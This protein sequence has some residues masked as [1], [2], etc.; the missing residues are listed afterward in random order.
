MKRLFAFAMAAVAVAHVALAETW[1]WS[2]TNKNGSYY[3]WHDGNNWTNSAATR[4]RPASGDTAVIGW[5][6]AGSGPYKVCNS[7]SSIVMEEVRFEGNKPLNMNQGVLYL[8]AGGGGLKYMLNAN[9]GDNWMGTRFVGTGEVPI[10]IEHAV[11]YALQGQVCVQSGSPTLVKTGA[12]KFICFNQAGYRAYNIPLTL[13]RQG[14]IDIT[15]TY[16][17][18]GID[19]AF[20]GNDESQR[21][22]YCYRAGDALDLKLKNIGFYETNGVANT[23]HGISAQNDNQ[24]LFTGTPKQNPTVFSGQFYVK[25]GLNW[26]PDSADYVFVCSNAVSATQG[27]VIVTKGTVKLVTGAS[28]TALSTLNVAAGAVFEVE[29]GSGA[30]FH[31]DTLTLADATSHLNLGEGVSLAIG[32]GTLNG[33]ALPRGTYSQDGA[34]DTRRAVWITGAGTVSVENGPDS[35][36]TWSGSGADNLTSTDANWASEAAPDVTAGDLLATFATGGTAAELP[37][38]TEAAFEGMVLDSSGLDGSSFAFTAGDGAT[39]TLGSSGLTA[40]AADSAFSWTMGWP[41]T[42]GGAQTWTVGENN[43]VVFNA[44]ISGE[45]ELAIDGDGTIDLNATSTHSGALTINSGTVNVR[46]DNALGTGDRTVKYY[47]DAANLNFYGDVTV[48]SPINATWT[49]TDSQQNGIAIGEGANARFNGKVTLYSQ[50]SV[51][52]GAGSTATFANGL[53]VTGNG[54]LGHLVLK[55]SGTVVVTNVALAARSTT[56]APSGNSITLVLYTAG[57]AMSA[58]GRYWTEF[59]SSTVVTRVPNAFAANVCMSLGSAGT[60]D[61]DGNNQTL[62][63]IYGTAGS[64]VTSA[65]PAKLTVNCYYVSES[66]N[67]SAVYSNTNSVDN[68]E[69]AGN[70]SFEKK[71]SYPH[72]LGAASSSTGTLSVA[73]GRLILTG[74]W[75]NCTNVVVTA[76]KFTV[77]NANAFGD[78]D[79]A[80][81]EKPKVALSVASGDAELELDYS[82]RIDCS[83]IL[84]DG[85]KSFGTFGAEGSGAEREVSWISGTGFVRALPS[86]TVMIFR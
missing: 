84:V 47:M 68:I 22:F 15:T 4:G 62:N 30:S 73:A 19:I 58:S 44:P 86:G 50:A 79:R 49:T 60:L 85:V 78:E 57:N 75:P 29:E 48:D 71:G 26:S 82:G 69:Y 17:L 61:M 76:G 45:A 16:T 65:K 2:P 7:S 11:N 43:T 12:G 66:Y 24:V 32:S 74:S 10:H 63:N 51:N 20:D 3:Y 37:A 39:M 64:T 83:A 28:F 13:I 8:R 34:N 72:N 25:A 6:T 38:S 9:R 54:M 41:I 56:L 14:A 81:G 40:A 55:G 35:V 46:A 23:T 67:Q 70:V 77:K 27:S 53:A 21:I 52:M 33:S 80:A 18:S 31:A 5:G 42:V 59:L 36:D 1:Y